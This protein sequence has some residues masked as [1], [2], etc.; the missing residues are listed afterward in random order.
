MLPGLRSEMNYLFPN[1][2]NSVS[3]TGQ[4]VERYFKFLVGGIQHLGACNCVS[5]L[6]ACRLNSSDSFLSGFYGDHR[7]QIQLQTARSIADDN[8]NFRLCQELAQVLSEKRQPRPTCQV[9]EG[10]V[11][12]VR[13]FDQEDMK[14]IWMSHGYSR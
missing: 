2:L 11:E 1:R 6:W 7:Q 10:M 4:Q 8:A 14:C 12:A 9:R 5:Q 3:G 13:K